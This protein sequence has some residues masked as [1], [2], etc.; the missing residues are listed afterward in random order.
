MKTAKLNFTGLCTTNVCEEIIGM[1]KNFK[2]PKGG[3]KYSNPCVSYGRVIAS[4]VLD[5]RFKFGVVHT[6]IAMET[7][8]E[9][10]TRDDFQARPKM[11]S[12]KWN[13]VQGYNQSPSWYSPSA[14]NTCTPN[15]DLSLLNDCKAFGDIH[16]IGQ[17]WLGGIFKPSHGFVFEYLQPNKKKIWIFPVVPFPESA[18]LALPLKQKIVDLRYT[19]FEPDVDSSFYLA[20]IVDIPKTSRA[21]LIRARSWLWQWIWIKSYR[22]KLGAEAIR[23]FRDG[24]VRPVHEIACR[25]GWWDMPRNEINSYSRYWGFVLTG[26][27]CFVSFLVEVSMGLTLC[28]ESAALDWVH[29]RVARMAHKA[30]FALQLLDIEEAEEV[31]DRDEKQKLAAAHK[32]AATL[33]QERN[34]F[35]RVYTARKLAAQQAKHGSTTDAAKALIGTKYPDV[36]PLSFLQGQV[37]RFL[38]PTASCWRGNKRAEWWA[39]V[40]PYP[41]IVEPV[42]R[43]ADERS[44][45]VS[46]L[47][48]AW[49]QYCER[50]ALPRT[51][52]PIQG[53]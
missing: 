4:G 49:D 32:S 6:D 22:K 25:C 8:G 12:A 3:A 41:R 48:Q 14:A 26:G 34:D 35:V 43:H 2:M 44:C 50:E 51:S 46:M 31:L 19:S 21:C 7:K 42:A 28:T 17:A 52:C 47:Q 10:L 33:I 20:S 45:I 37:K 1:S 16:L 24:D 38:P 40:K 36:L 29:G 39:H 11:W 9:R 23:I 5:K 27:S 13:E 15:A 53:L 30:K 18:V